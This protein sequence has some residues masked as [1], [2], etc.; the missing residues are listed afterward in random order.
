MGFFDRFRK[1]LARKRL[2]ELG[3]SA[4]PA[5][6]H[7]E[8]K[9]APTAAKP[10]PPEKPK[11]RRGE[12]EKTRRQPGTMAYRIILHPLVSEKATRLQTLNQYSFA[13]DVHAKKPE[14]RQ[15]I[16]ELY[17]VMPIKV[18]VQHRT[19]KTVRYGRTFGRTAS[20]KKAIV[21]LQPGQLIE[22]TESR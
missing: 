13:V 1:Q 20:W 2:S 3:T 10:E 11:T 7:Q 14:I 17:G 8:K 18:D 12:K 21:T 4:N 16:S 22:T 19:G 5:Q 9:V 6:E 15:A